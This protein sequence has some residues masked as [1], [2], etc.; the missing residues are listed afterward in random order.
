MSCTAL[1]MRCDAEN[2]IQMQMGT[3]PDD[4]KNWRRYSRGDLP[5]GMVA[6]GATE[7]DVRCGGGGGGGRGGCAAEGGRGAGKARLT[8]IKAGTW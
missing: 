1:E 5:V 6:T 3:A 8:V 2:D 4:A 7:C